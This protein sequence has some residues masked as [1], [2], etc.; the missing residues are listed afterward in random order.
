[1]LLNVT[2][3][4]GNPQTV[5]ATTQTVPAQPAQAGLADQSDFVAVTNVS[6]QVLAPNAQRSWW[7]IQNQGQNDMWVNDLGNVASNSGADNNGS[8]R[9]A[10]GESWP[11]AGAPVCTA[12]VFVL[13]TA[14]D[15]FAARENTG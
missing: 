12:A 3:A 7:Y 15:F 14:G 5:V 8:I 10:P 1:M 6:Q 2:D 9:V 13:G 11:P 4:L